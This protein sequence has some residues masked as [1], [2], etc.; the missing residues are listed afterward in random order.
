MRRLVLLAATAAVIAGTA[1]TAA[2]ASAADLSCP[3]SVARQSTV[4][5]DVADGIDVT[6]CGGAKTVVSDGVGVVIPDEGRGITAVALG[7]DGH[8]TVLTVVTDA[9]GVVDVRTEE[10]AAGTSGATAATVNRCSDGSNALMG[11][12]W[13]T[14][15][16]YA[17]NSTERRPS[18]ISESTWE[19]V[20]GS[21]LRT[22][23]TGTNSCGL[24]P[25]LSTPGYFATNSL[26][27]SNISST[28]TCTT[29][30]TTS[31][32]DFGS[33]SGSTLG[34]TCVAFQIRTGHDKIVAADV[35]LDNSS[36][37]WVTSVSGCSGARYDLRSALTHEFGHAYGLNHA[38]ERGG[39]DLTMSPTIAACN[40][41]ARSLGLGDVRGMTALYPG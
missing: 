30:N 4:A 9:R 13:Y 37:G 25:K 41:S 1:V 34:L 26:A 31:V 3:Q 19:S 27:D 17:V 29:P 11:A 16:R 6:S 40:G 35:R 15:P 22:I 28:N 24:T 33:L 20:V 10:H 38:V 5:A 8:E 7:G 39:N 12:K 36:R 21:S 32:V 2:P 18:Y 23:K 14:T